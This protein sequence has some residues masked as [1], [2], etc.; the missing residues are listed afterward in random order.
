MN[1]LSVN[2]TIYLG[3]GEVVDVVTVS[4]PTYKANAR[5]VTAVD[6]VNRT[7]TLS[8]ATITAASGDSIVLASVDSTSG[9]PN[10]DLNRAINGLANI[11]KGSGILHT[12]NPASG[13]GFW[14]SSEI[15]AAGATVGDNLL[16]QL[17]DSVGKASGDDGELI[18]ITTR[19]IRNRYAN[20]L[21]AFKQFNDAQSVTL[22]GGF[23][24]LLFDDK[25][26]V[27]DDMCQKG[28]VYA[29]NT[30]YMFWSQMSDWDWLD[31]DG[32]TLKWEPRYDRFV[33]VLYKYCNLGT[34]Q[35]NRHGLIYGAADDAE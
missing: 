9:T 2:T 30:K 3:L 16:R 17:T 26:M 25:P 21:T 14:V 19:G 6:P 35:R 27:I 22:R 29:L 24:A 31:Q 5:V 13:N 11:V 18:L 32:T 8:G 1:T 12:L 10:N 7:V 33:G 4:G 15:N 28:T 23:K 20:Q 34:T